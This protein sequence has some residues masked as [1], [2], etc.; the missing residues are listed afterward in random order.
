MFLIKSSIKQKR[1]DN[2][3]KQKTKIKSSCLGCKK[4]KRLNKIKKSNKEI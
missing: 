4:I 3:R 1:K 2:M